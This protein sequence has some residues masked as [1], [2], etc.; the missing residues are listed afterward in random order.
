M[1]SWPQERDSWLAAAAFASIGRPHLQ[2][3][4]PPHRLPPRPLLQGGLTC[5][6]VDPIAA[7]KLSGVGEWDKVGYTKLNL[8]GLAG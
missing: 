6:R 8:W 7:P 4:P 2:P 3:H 1:P 5:I